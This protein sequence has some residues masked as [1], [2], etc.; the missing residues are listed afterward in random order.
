MHPSFSAAA[1]AYIA[2]RD[3]GDTAGARVALS[4]AIKAQRLNNR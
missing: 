2:A 4:A 1:A 3:A